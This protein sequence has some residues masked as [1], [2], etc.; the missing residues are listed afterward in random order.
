MTD[1]T[2]SSPPVH[3]AE[4]LR[5]RAES[6][7]LGPGR[8]LTAFAL[9]LL[10]GACGGSDSATDGGAGGA[11]GGGGP[12]GAA[13]GAGA[14]VLDAG[15]DVVEAGPDVID[16]PDPVPTIYAGASHTC[17]LRLSGEVI[18]WGDGQFGKLGYGNEDNIGDDETPASVGVVDVGGTP[19]ALIANG[20]ATCALLDDQSVKCWGFA[21]GGQL[22]YGNADP[23]GDDE[24]PSSVGSIDVGGAVAQVSGK[25]DHACA[26]RTDGEVVCWGAANDGRLGYGNTENVGDDETPASVGPVSV[27]APVRYVGAGG[28]HTCVLL[29]DGDVKCWG[30]GRFGKTGRGDT[31][32]TGDD[33]TPDSLGTVDL[34]GK[35]TQLSVGH[36]H[37]CVLLESGDVVCWGRNQQGQIGNASTSNVGDDETPASVGPVDVGGG[38][39][40]RVVA[41]SQVTCVLFDDGAV[42]CWGLGFN[43]A[44]G[45]GNLDSIGDDEL[46]SAVGNVD[47]GAPAVDLALGGSLTCVVTDSG[48]VRCWGFG[49]LGRLGYGNT[50]NVGD[51]ETPASVG[52]VPA[53]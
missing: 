27:G 47:V 19:V 52:D 30:Q 15:P 12:G 21:M 14:P 40:V 50:D 13:G 46:P 9:A 8:I 2:S 3:R 51:D 41:G 48:N 26:L 16:P 4:S 31:L 28:N 32:D 17:H 42:K 23:I 10:L 7:L 24:L 39:V 36:S 44:L 43:G 29:E 5:S 49:G 45:Y 11:G 6:L 1:N 35:A 18:C 37:N 34:G 38:T 25:L 33:E 20:A 53:F 22:G